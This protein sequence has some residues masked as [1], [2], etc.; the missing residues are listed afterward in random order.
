M[1]EQGHLSISAGLEMRYVCGTVGIPDSPARVYCCPSLAYAL[2]LRVTIAV[3][4]AG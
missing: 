4:H 2:T 1:D 3:R